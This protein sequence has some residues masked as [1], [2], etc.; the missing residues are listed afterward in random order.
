MTTYHTSLGVVKSG[1]NTVGEI[2]NF[3]FDESASLEEDQQLTDASLS[4][5]LGKTSWSGTMSMR[6]DPDDAGQS[7]LTIGASVTI[8]FHP[9]GIVSGD[10]DVSGTAFVEEI[11]VTNGEDGAIMKEITMRGSGDLTHGNVA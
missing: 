8:H 11:T 9:E 5:L 3:T 10:V 1:S 2:V 4:F 6:W 7:D